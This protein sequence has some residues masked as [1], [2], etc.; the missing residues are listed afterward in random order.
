MSN[1]IGMLEPVIPARNDL[2]NTSALDPPPEPRRT[3]HIVRMTQDI[4]PGDC[5]DVL[6]AGI[7]DNVGLSDDADDHRPTWEPAD[8]EAV[9]KLVAAQVMKANHWELIKRMAAGRERDARARI[10]RI[11]AAYQDRL[12]CAMPV[13]GKSRGKWIGP[14]SG[15]NYTGQDRLPELKLVDKDI[16]TAAGLTRE[17]I[18]IE[19]DTAAVRAALAGG[20]DVA[21]VEV[22]EQLPVSYTAPKI[23]GDS[24]AG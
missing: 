12:T 5:L 19:L 1:T 9:D 23:K 4:Y 24:D 15:G 17:K 14:Y 7:D 6:L 11:V 2:S 16:A 3:M 8:A 10:D 21:G 18:T 20:S 13:P 22:T